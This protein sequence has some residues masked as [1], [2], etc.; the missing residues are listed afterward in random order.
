MNQKLLIV[1][2][3][4]LFSA[5]AFPT[6]SSAEGNNYGSADYLQTGFGSRAIGLGG[7]FV[8]LADDATAAYWNPAGLSQMRLYLYAANL[9]YAWLPR[10]MGASFITYAIQWPVMGSFCISWINFNAGKQE[11][12]DELGEP[13]GFEFSTAENTFLFSYGR[14]LYEWMYGLSVGANLKIL[15]QAIGNH[16]A[17]GYG[18]DVGLLWQP[19]LYWEHVFGV[20][21]QNLFQRLH[22]NTGAGTDRSLVTVRAGV[23]LKFL[24]SE[25]LLFFNHLIFTGD[26]E[27]TED[28]RVIPHAGVE[29]WALTS[30]GARAGYSSEG[31]TV[32]ASYRPDYYQLDYV[33][34]YDISKLSAHQHRVSVQMRFK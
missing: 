20:N 2:A 25:D 19:I 9:E 12:W 26:M 29:W 8:A 16:S 11:G 10:D 6:L 18:L 5:L 21:V 13:S 27:Y 31:V 17:V 4:L 34:R 30:L 24:R 28:E 1:C 22:W 3:F 32:G 15:Q 14:E 7:A 23:A 33:F